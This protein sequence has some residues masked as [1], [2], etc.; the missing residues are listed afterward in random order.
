M[1]PVVQVSTFS[2]GPDSIITHYVAEIMKQRP[3]LLIQSDAVLKE[4][5]HL[6]NRENT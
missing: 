1:L 2:C 3:F 6:E 4:L 5:A